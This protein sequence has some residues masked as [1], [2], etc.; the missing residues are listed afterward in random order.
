VRIPWR[1]REYERTCADCGYAWRVPKSAVRKPVSGFSMAP[2]G[3]PVSLGGVNPVVSANEPELVSSEAI[4]ET[5]AAFGYCPKCASE[6]F[7]QRP[8]RP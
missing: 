1:A 4:S 6:N 7:R 2:R 3:R 8:I 5:A